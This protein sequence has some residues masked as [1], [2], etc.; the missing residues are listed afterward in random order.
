MVAIAVY[1]LHIGHPGTLSK[2]KMLSMSENPKIEV[3]EGEPK[4]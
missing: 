2:G 1:A 3:E 4:L